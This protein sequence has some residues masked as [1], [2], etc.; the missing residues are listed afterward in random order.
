[1]T[2]YNLDKLSEQKKIIIQ[3]TEKE[4][5][6]IKGILPSLIREKAI[7]KN[8]DNVYWLFPEII[9]T[10]TP[11]ILTD[12]TLGDLSNKPTKTEQFDNFENSDKFY[13]KIEKSKTIKII[14]DE[15]SN[16]LNIKLYTGFDLIE[17]KWRQFIITQSGLEK[18]KQSKNPKD[19]RKEVCDHKV[20][21]YTLSELFENF[22]QL[23]ASDEYIKKE[24]KNSDK[25]EDSLINLIK[26]TK[27]D[28]YNFPLSDNELKILQDAR[29]RCMHFRVTSPQSY[30]E[31]VEKINKYLKTEALNEFTKNI[32]LLPSF[33][34]VQKTMIQMM[35]NIEPQ[36]DLIRRIFSEHAKQTKSAVKVIN[37]FNKTI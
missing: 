18:I 36:M 34:E 25:S 32:I 30:K 33:L 21:Q 1:M 16:E 9:K 37:A 20:S 31:T 7:E 22:L 8:T 11:K 27:I 23:T 29:N 4:I 26:L 28:E 19:Y 15:F 12:I 5:N 10:D 2:V 6:E 14:I 17:G 35:E 24:W 13:Q 3:A